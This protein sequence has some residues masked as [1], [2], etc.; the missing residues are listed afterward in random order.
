MTPPLTG[1]RV[2]DL[3]QVMAGPFCC[4]VLGDLGADVIKV[5]PPGTGDQSRH[6]MGFR[7]QGE[8]TAAFLAVNR[9]KR[10]AALNLKDPAH[11]DAFI[12]LAGTADVLIE[13]FRPGVTARLGIDYETLAARHP[14]LVYASISGFGQTGPYALRPGFD[15]IA[16]GVAGVMSV[17]G[18]PGG[19]PVKC[20]IPISDLSAGLFCAIGV[21]AALRARETSGRGQHVDTS[22]FEGALALSIW[23]TAELWATGRVPAP[24]GS[25]HR[26]TAP[27]QALRTRDG[28]ITVGGNNERL[29][30]R[31]CTAL[32][33]EDLLADE[34]FAGNDARMSNR[35]EL[36]AELEAALVGAR[37]RRLG[38]D[39]A[40]GRRAV[41]ADPRLCGGGRRSPHAR[42]RD[43]GRARAP[44]RG[45]GARARHAAQALRHAGRDPAAAAA[46]GRAHR[47]GA[48]RGGPRGGGDRG[49]GM[50]ELLAERRGPALWVT[51]N[52]PEARNAMTFAMYEALFER[53]EEADGDESVRALVLRGAG[54]KA[55]VA[56]T[57][58][59]QF[60]AFE[61]GE[62][63]LRYEATID[64]IVGRLEAVAKP[65][66]A[67]VDGYAMGS[68]LALSAVCDLRVC[69][70][71]AT[72]GLPIARTVG[73]CLSMENYA[74]LAALLGPARVKDIIF[75]ARSIGAEEALAIG[76]ATEVVEPGEAEAHVEA[77]CE[78]LASHAAVT[79][80]VTKEA[81]RRVRAA[82]TPD[83]D[84]LVREAYASEEFRRTVAAWSQKD[85]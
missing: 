8:D 17:T 19:E 33:R 24:L 58:I 48:A 64:R 57:D 41:R 16:Q 44:R 72:F 81:L 80:R 22:L 2:L 13:N 46:A 9:N 29:W 63:G 7:M 5:E 77:L 83:G 51:F 40:G 6:A 15:L 20:G 12:R 21:L 28:H 60:T 82:T 49:A 42:A 39:P 23:E 65:T 50:T 3:T 85:R 61:S 25:S 32:G 18:E 1:L 62:D 73:N 11:R 35:R 79:L 38:R 71:A 55:F 26:L 27:Y 31:L 14:R 30:T 37:H 84:D 68:G 43:G 69:T 78:R 74:R 54:D 45:D 56:G 53:C 52:R 70:P 76:L 10:S 75:T 47:G 59:N 66:V 67:L 34:R 4:Q 36:E